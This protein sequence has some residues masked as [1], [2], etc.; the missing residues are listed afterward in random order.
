MTALSD[1]A[2]VKAIFQQRAICSALGIMWDASKEG[3]GVGISADTA[4]QP[5]PTKTKE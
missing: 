3:V 4:L 5:S 1:L 2:K